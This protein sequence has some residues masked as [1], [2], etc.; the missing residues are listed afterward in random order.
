MLSSDAVAL[1]FLICINRL[2][3][4][5]VGGILHI[6]KNSKEIIEPL[7]INTRL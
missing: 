4:V 2:A 3:A 5:S 1:A 6:L 7:E